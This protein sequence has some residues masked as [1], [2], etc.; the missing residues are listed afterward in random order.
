MKL[1]ERF[2]PRSALALALA[3]AAMI[4]PLCGFGA[5]RLFHG[6]VVDSVSG[7]P[8]EIPTLFLL[9]A[10]HGVVGDIDGR[11]SIQAAPDDTL[12]VSSVGYSTRFIPLV[13]L[14]SR[15]LGAVRLQRYDTELAEV[16][17]RPGK[18]K[19][20]KKNNPAYDLMVEIR[21]KADSLDPIRLPDHNYDFYTRYV[22]GLNDFEVTDRSP[23]AMRFLKAYSDTAA[24]TGL[25]VVLLSIKEKTGTRLLQRNPA[26]DKTVTAGLRSEGIDKAFN[27]ENIRRMLEDVL[28]EVDIYSGDITL[29]Q[30]RFVSPLSPLAGDYYRYYITDTIKS[31]SDTLVELSFAP[32]TPESFGFNGRMEV[33]RTA[34]GVPYVKRLAMRVPRVI[35]L[36]YVD[37]IIINQEFSIDSLGNRQKTLDDMTVEICLIPGTQSFYGRRTTVNSNFSYTP[38]V[39]LKEYYNRSGHLFDVDGY[40]L[41][42]ADFWKQHRLVPLSAAEQQLNHFR[43]SAGSM[44]WFRWLEKILLVVI[45]GYLT[46]SDPSYFDVG[47]MLSVFSFNSVEGFRMRLGGM[48]TACLNPH[49]FARFY[50]AYGFKDHRWKYGVE[51]EY[52]IT[53]KKVHSR[54]FPIHSIR[55]S[56]DYDLDM[57]GQRYLNAGADNLILS[58]KR[59][60]SNLTTYRRRS[61]LEYTLEL[62]NN[63][64]IRAGL[65]HEIQF[66][67]RWV[68]FRT[69]SGALV[70]H[71]SQAAFFVNLRYAPGE[72]FIEGKNKR[73]P[74]NMDAPVFEILHEYSPRG[75]L[76]SYFTLNRTEISVSKRFWFSAFGYADVTLKGGKIWSKVQFPA[77]LWPGTNLSYTVQRDSYSLM[78][79]MEFANDHY[80]SLDLTYWMNGLIFNRIPVVKRAKLRE[81]LIFKLLMGGLTGRNN[82]ANDDTLFRFPYDSGTRTMTST[83]YMEIG[84][85]IE[86]ILTFLRVDYVWRLTYRDTPGIDRSGLRLSVHFSF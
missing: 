31:P 52:S 4:C 25:P 70:P 50:T 1:N 41:R 46:T 17:I 23:R 81:I 62:R 59:M 36:N 16:V 34:A 66:A 80:G 2:N 26:R 30:N 73:A 65:R 67:T 63:F 69:G 29:M 82:P 55:L 75:F 5:S 37:N 32:R 84:C 77:L 18:R 76:G 44:K 35:N 54:E 85:G 78:N 22:L 12:R 79:P 86:N 11:F 51:G 28:R 58:I 60:E 6:H 13:Q 49:L 47:P 20:S 83:P 38:R 72:S 53:R 8:V 24:N 33:A 56:H 48:T 19:Y 39:D 21:E 7:D 40:D 64:S 27:Q 57:I 68:P 10:G 3:V 14:R 74:I 71:Y 15:N 43:T 9:K 61:Q 42:P 45:D